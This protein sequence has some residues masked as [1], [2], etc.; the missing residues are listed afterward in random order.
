MAKL[1][2]FS[3]LFSNTLDIDEIN[4]LYTVF[5]KINK[6]VKLGDKTEMHS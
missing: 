5:N 4:R 1:K 6:D 3:F 2:L